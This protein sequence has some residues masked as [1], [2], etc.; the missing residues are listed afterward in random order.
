M[1]ADDPTVSTP[2]RPEG[3]VLTGS[4][5][6][7]AHRRRRRRAVGLALVLLVVL[8][9]G[10]AVRKADTPPTSSEP[11]A[12]RSEAAGEPGGDGADVD[13]EVDR[14][15]SRP[16]FALG[17][18]AGDGAG[19]LDG[20]DVADAW[21]GTGE[22]GPGSGSGSGSLDP[23]PPQPDPQPPGGEVDDPAEEGDQG[24]GATDPSP[25]DPCA[26]LEPGA[27]LVTTPDPKHLNPGS[28]SS[29]LTIRN[30][31]PDVVE[32][33]AA[34]KPSVTLAQASGSLD[35]GATTSVG[36]TIDPSAF[37]DDAIA[38]KIKVSEPGFSQYVDISATKAGLADPSDPPPDPGGT[39]TTGGPSGC[40]A[41]CITKAWLTPNATTPNLALDVE[42]STPARVSVFV[43]TSAPEAGPD[44]QPAFPEGGLIAATNDLNVVWSTVLSP[45]PPATDHHIIV[46]ATD[47]DGGTS[48]RVGTFRTVTPAVDPGLDEAAPGPDSGCSTQCI[49]KAWLTPDPES[50]DM[51]LEVTSHTLA[52]FEATVS[53]D[54]PT[55]DEDDRPSFPGVAPTATNFAY[56]TSWTTHLGPLEPA[57][58]YHVIVK[59]TDG[60]F[61][62]SYQVGSF[63]TREGPDRLLVSFHRVEVHED[64]D[65]GA[66]RG[67]LR[68]AF[69]IGGDL[70]ASTGERKIGS[71]ST[72][73]LSD[74]N[75]M[76]GLDTSV[77][78]DPSPSAWLPSLHAVAFE[79]DWD[80]LFEFCSVGA[81]PLD[82]GH[83]D[84]CDLKWDVASSGLIQSGG[85]GS[86]PS[87][88]DLGIDAEEVSGHR[89]LRL[90]S[91]GNGDDYP[92]FSV[93]VSLAPIVT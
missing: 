45:L 27:N 7:A 30:C 12:E 43:S 70:V 46:R 33:T 48:S 73:N 90:E 25:S 34:T 80:G 9:G 2:I 71:G 60:L 32:W 14:E 79:R 15:E 8:L 63:E 77:A 58:T 35:G 82:Q 4:P 85:L 81:A 47:A 84:G 52:R 18:D 66:N 50:F 41:S 44:G 78:F 19:A 16:G 20:I 11:G 67:E 17:R 1:A 6:R 24:G 49:T 3:P 39:L 93:I 86:L 5:G 55:F 10:L 56:E 64:G 31:G 21:P 54:E 62:S 69:S 13:I 42:T 92:R 38:F 76:P 91:V 87:C 36:F 51:E 72:V 57:T 37:S 75:R 53:T 23:T 28:T 29:A 74:G 59:A 22:S 88:A 40:A 68:F 61:R 89:C 26:A 65:R 83:H